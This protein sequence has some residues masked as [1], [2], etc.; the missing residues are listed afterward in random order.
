MFPL[1][2][3]TP[4]HP[5]ALRWQGGLQGLLP[6]GQ[7]WSPS[8]EALAL[9]LGNESAPEIVPYYSRERGD[10]FVFGHVTGRY[11]GCRVEWRAEK[12]IVITQGRDC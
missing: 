12:F 11:T 7:S 4:D 9:A 3:K 10:F 5:P 1:L 6:R 8:V 2:V